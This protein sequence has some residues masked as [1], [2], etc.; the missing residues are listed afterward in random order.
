MKVNKHFKVGG[1]VRA[2]KSTF[3]IEMGGIYKVLDLDP[4]RPNYIRVMDDEGDGNTL[5]DLVDYELF[6]CAPENEP[7]LAFHLDAY[8]YGVVGDYLVV[9]KENK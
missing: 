8:V 5:L 9:I 7:P 6:E 2:K 1:Y 3:G 4:N